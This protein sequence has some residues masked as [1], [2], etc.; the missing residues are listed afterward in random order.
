MSR[1]KLRIYPKDEYIIREGDIGKEMFFILKGKVSVLIKGKQVAVLTKGQ[2]LG[3]MALIG[4]VRTVRSASA[5]CISTVSLGI[6]QLEDFRIIEKNYPRF[7]E[8]IEKVVEMRRKE[9]EK[10]KE[11]REEGMTPTHMRRRISLIP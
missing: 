1:L 9:N 10:T 4:E 8:H 2:A 6:L 7:Q 5:K 3:E 11:E